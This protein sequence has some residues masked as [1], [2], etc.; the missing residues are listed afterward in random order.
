MNGQPYKVSSFIQS[1]RVGIL[2]DFLGLSDDEAEQRLEDIISDEAYRNLLVHRAQKNTAL[3]VQIFGSMPDNTYKITDFRRERV[4]LNDGRNKGKAALVKKIRGVLVNFPLD[5]LK[6]EEM[7]VGFFE[8]EK[9]VP[10]V[11]FL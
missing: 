5:F 1:L 9:Y 4:N 10:R 2:R 7:N 6:D 3:Y 8:K 11:T